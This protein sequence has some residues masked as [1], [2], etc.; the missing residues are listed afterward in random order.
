MSVF[1]LDSLLLFIPYTLTSSCIF[2][3]L[4]SIQG[5]SKENL[6]NNQ[7]MVRFQ[8]YGHKW[9]IGLKYEYELTDA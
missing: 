3:I 7:D 6:L 1:H 8:V 4:L 2:S 5:A 9:Q